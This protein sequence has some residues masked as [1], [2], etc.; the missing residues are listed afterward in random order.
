MFLLAACLL[1]SRTALAALPDD[2]IE[3]VKE[4]VPDEQI[5]TRIAQSPPSVRLGA[6][7]ALW[8]KAAGVSDAVLK[9][10]IDA[11]ATAPSEPPSTLEVL[12]EPV[13][14][15]T[16]PPQ[17]KLVV[18]TVKEII[19]AHE[20]GASTAELIRAVRGLYL[21]IG[22]AD[23][24]RLESAGVP[25]SVIRAATTSWQPDAPIRDRSS[26]QVDRV[27]G[28]DGKTTFGTFECGGGFS[29]VSLGDATT[30]VARLSPGLHAIIASAISLGVEA[31]F[32][33]APG[34]AGR[35]MLFAVVGAGIPTA[36][37]FL[38]RLAGRFGV[39]A[40]DGAAAY[41]FSV[42]GLGRFGRLLV[43]VGLTG[44]WSG[45]PAVSVIAADLRIG[46]WF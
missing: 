19:A 34:D 23:R 21:R 11:S 22:R 12:P 15:P 2:V 40:E 31:D 29:S 44:T 41:G 45:D 9:A 10:L 8:L 7:D 30:I 46:T 3:W 28:F 35:T 24:N 25:Y 43:G 14:P 18:K 38:L 5:I 37:N 13:E 42:A 20:D 32:S 1:T 17:P 6:H 36:S 26:P 16:R 4:G 33:F 27:K 39:D